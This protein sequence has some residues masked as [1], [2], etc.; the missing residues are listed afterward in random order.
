VSGREKALSALALVLMLFAA[1]SLRIVHFRR[2][3]PIFG[4]ALGGVAYVP[5]ASAK[6][7]ADAR[8]VRRSILRT[9]RLS[10]ARS[11]CLP[12]AMVAA[13]LCRL[14]GVPAA[15]HLGVKLDDGPRKIDAHA[16]VCS[17]PEAICGG[18]G[19]GRYTPVSCFV[20]MPSG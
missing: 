11:D 12:Q 6:Q 9:V 13:I 8:M 1:V 10:P 14:L 19:F 20:I 3:A 15:V 17:G 18:K 4:K 7:R 16:W 5:F 2:I